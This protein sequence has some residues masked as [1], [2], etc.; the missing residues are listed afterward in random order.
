MKTLDGMF[1][2]D[3]K[4]ITTFETSKTSI[5]LQLICSVSIDINAGVAKSV[6]TT[7]PC[8]PI[9]SVEL[10]SIT[11]AFSKLWAP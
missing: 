5:A 6:Y 1:P 10:A 2:N 11:A 3:P 8:H 9:I 7:A 4:N